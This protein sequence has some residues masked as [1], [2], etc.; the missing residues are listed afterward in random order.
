M[1]GTRSNITHGNASQDSVD[2]QA[3]VAAVFM[4]RNALCL[5]RPTLCDRGNKDVCIARAYKR[6]ERNPIERPFRLG[7]LLIDYD[8][9]T[10]VANPGGLAESLQ[11]AALR[12]GGSGFRD[13]GAYHDF[14]GES[15]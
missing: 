4:R 3:G 6:A 7:Q 5:L 15:G 13:S 2:F 11:I 12:H 9:D 10:L 14:I 1:H 8:I